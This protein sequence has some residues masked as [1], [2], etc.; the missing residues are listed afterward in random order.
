M[1]TRGKSKFADYVLYYKP[2]IPIAIIEAKDNNHSVGDG[3]QQG[4]N[5]GESLDVPFVFS[6]N[7]DAFLEHDRTLSTGTI[8][9]ELPRDAFPSPAAL[10]QRYCVW[11]GIE[12][13]RQQQIVAQDYYSDG[14]GRLPRYYQLTAINRT[15]EAIAR[16]QKRILLVMATGTGKTIPP[17]RSSGGSGNRARK[18]AS[19]SWPTATS[20]STRPA[21]TISS[22]SAR[23]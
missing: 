6:S 12:L 14:S 18:S 7:G 3:M 13:P 23:R 17:S 4:L 1:V 21:P 10:W 16:G 5:Y 19:C 2:N 9:C 15:I 20:W 8:E 22:P 11:K